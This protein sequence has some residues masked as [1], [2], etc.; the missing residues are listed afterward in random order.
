MS[1]ENMSGE[2]ITYSDGEYQI[3]DQP[4]IGAMSGDGSL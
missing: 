2:Y 3:P 1:A 4:M